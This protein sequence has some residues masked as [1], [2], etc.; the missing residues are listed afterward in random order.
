M[1]PQVSLTKVCCGYVVDLQR[2]PRDVTERTE[3]HHR[4][5]WGCVLLL[6]PRL[7]SCALV[8]L[9]RPQMVGEEIPCTLGF[10]AVDLGKRQRRHAA[11]GG[12]AAELTGAESRGVGLVD[13]VALER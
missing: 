8:R 12:R 7:L 6:L 13:C 9:L 1:F 2:A 10:N 4:F 11:G 3:P 5:P